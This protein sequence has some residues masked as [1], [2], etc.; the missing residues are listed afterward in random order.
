VQ[1]EHGAHKTG[2]QS[3]ARARRPA[4]KTTKATARTYA[5]P[6]HPEV[7][8]KSARA[9]CPKC[10]MTLVKR[11]ATTTAATGGGDDKSD[12]GATTNASPAA[13]GSAAPV[14]EKAAS[15]DAP[16]SEEAAQR[17]MAA[18]SAKYFPR[19]ILITQDNQ[20]MRFYDDLLKGKVVLINFMFTTCTGVCSPM[21]A[22]LAKVQSYL[23]E[24]VGREVRMLSIT[25]DPVTDTPGALKAYAAKYKTGPG[26]YFLTGKK[27]NVDWVLY[28]LGAYTEDKTTHSGVLIVG[29]EA[30][31]DWMKIPAMAKPSEIAAAVIKLIE[32]GGEQSRR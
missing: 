5:C 25:V 30:T 3:G 21:T 13:N 9:K 12:A 22:N 10:G 23:G 11:S 28:K 7:T 32:K 18:G 4:P 20:P 6:M 8:S 19:H 1:H 27:E 15:A 2:A 31:G 29:N 17:K 24:R 14:P 16:D 26:W